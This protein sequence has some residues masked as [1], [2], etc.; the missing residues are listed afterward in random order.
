VPPDTVRVLAYNIHHGEGM[1]SVVDLERI[2]AL[3][4]SVDPDLVALQEIDSVTERTGQVD[5]AAELG[6]LTGLEPVFGSFMPYQGGAYGMAVLSR[7]PVEEAVN[8]R[9]P[10]GEEPR[11][12]VRVTVVSPETGR[13]IRLVGV[14]FY[15]TEEERLAQA[16]SLD[17]QLAADATPTILAG[18]FNST[19]GSAVMAQLA[20]GWRVLPKGEDRLTYSSFDPVREIDF[21]L[22]RPRDRWELIAQD[23]MDE[24]VASDHRPVFAELVVTEDSG[25]TP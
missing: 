22:V 13:R 18:D 12:S 4:Q 20:E 7:W 3:I 9:L 17:E 6:R 11:S 25:G 21:I 19:P 15:R 1:D 5:Q 10:E 24:P 16:R 8:L 14:H 2:A 23:V